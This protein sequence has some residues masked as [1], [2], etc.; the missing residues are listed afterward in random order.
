MAA[1]AAPGGCAT[2]P[3]LAVR[4]RGIPGSRECSAV[5]AGDPIGS[6]DST[7]GTAHNAEHD[8]TDG[9]DDG[10]AC[11]ATFGVQLRA[12]GRTAAGRHLPEMRNRGDEYTVRV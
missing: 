9:L 12:A 6:E 11:P 7:T 3:N 8:R 10:V 5:L 1:E 2:R 4:P